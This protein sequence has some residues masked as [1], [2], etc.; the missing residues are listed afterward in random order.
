MFVKPTVSLFN[1]NLWLGIPWVFDTVSSNMPWDRPILIDRVFEAVLSEEFRTLCARSAHPH[2]G[3]PMPLLVQEGIAVV[4]GSLFGQYGTLV[5]F[6]QTEVSVVFQREALFANAFSKK[7]PFKGLTMDN[8]LVR[9]SC[10]NAR[11]VTEVRLQKKG[12]CKIDFYADSRSKNRLIL[13]MCT[14]YRQLRPLLAE[15]W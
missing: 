8:V 10:I 13:S 9:W 2:F 11:R 4:T 12:V 1:P 7:L 3:G 6:V 5:R 15:K 14:S